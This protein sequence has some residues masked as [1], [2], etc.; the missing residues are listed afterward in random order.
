MRE[1]S[2]FVRARAHSPLG[3]AW[4]LQDLAKRYVQLGLDT[5]PY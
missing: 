4:R 5:V 1:A 2:S 3:P